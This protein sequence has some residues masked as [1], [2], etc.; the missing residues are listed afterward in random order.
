MKMSEDGFRIR[1]LRLRR[2]VPY[3]G[4]KMPQFGC[5]E[6]QSDQKGE[7][8]LS[9]APSGRVTRSRGVVSLQNDWIQCTET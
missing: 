9:G 1:L 7:S 5:E 2:V 3:A 6:E 8:A 4:V